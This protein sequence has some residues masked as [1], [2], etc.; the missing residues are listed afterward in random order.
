MR[1]ETVGKCFDPYDV[2]SVYQGLHRR[3]ISVTRRRIQWKDFLQSLNQVRGERKFRS[4]R[5]LFKIL[6]PLGPGNGN[7]VLTLRQ[8]PR[9]G[10]LAGS[11]AGLCR[12]LPELIKQF[13]IA[14]EVLALESWTLAAIVVRGKIIGALEGSR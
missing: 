13:K 10:K 5:I 6:A 9:Q 7:N 1:F 2:L 12:Q 14:L 3:R 4:R 8:H 11:H